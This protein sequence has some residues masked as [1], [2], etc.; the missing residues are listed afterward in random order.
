TS[1]S[2]LSIAGVKILPTAAISALCA[3][4]HARFQTD[5]LPATAPQRGFQ[6]HEPNYCSLLPRR[7]CCVNPTAPTSSV[8]SR[9][10]HRSSSTLSV[11][12][13]RQGPVLRRRSIASEP[14]YLPPY[15]YPR[16]LR[17]RSPVRFARRGTRL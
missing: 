2:V 12:S 8:C 10:A 13:R 15:K 5:P 14:R 3:F 6:A 1:S 16:G 4:S 17:L 9:S 7:Y 11:I